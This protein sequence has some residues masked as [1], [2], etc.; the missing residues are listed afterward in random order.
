MLMV[1]RMQCQP[2]AGLCQLLCLCYTCLCN[3]Q[4]AGLPELLICKT[5]VKTLASIKM[6]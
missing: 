5:G 4:D 2:C 6:L 3:P 1:L